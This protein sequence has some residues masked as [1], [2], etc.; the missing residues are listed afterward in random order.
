[1][2]Y[3]RRYVGDFMRDTA[4]LSLAEVGAYDRLLD[5]QYG[6]EAGLPVDLQALCRVCHAG[7][8]QDRKVVK[9][10][11]ETYFPIVE[12]LRWNPRARRELAVGVTA[13]EKMKEGGRAGAAKRWGKDGAPHEVSDGQGSWG[14]DG[15]TH[16]ASI[17]PP[18][19]IHQ[20][21]DKPKIK[22]LP[23]AALA[24]DEQPVLVLKSAVQKHNSGIERE[25]G[26]TV[27]VWFAYADA[28]R[29]RY[30]VEPVRNRTVNAQLAQL[31]SRL[32]MEAAPPVASFYVAH[33]FMLY[34]RAKHPVNLLLRDA[35]GLHTE[36]RR[37][38]TV[39]SAE[40]QQ[41]DRTAGI[42]QVWK[43]LIEE[44][45]AEERVTI[46]ARGGDDDTY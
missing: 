25:A 3:Y 28:Y 15:V 35:E 46:A 36:W 34:V 32:G 14:N 37:G 9:Q 30:G 39:T 42:G 13:I 2:N 6:T 31:V 43:N 27:P 17:H 29:A 20:P 21:P 11:A 24:A 16:R 45:E 22:S 38:R 1:M 4:H 12:G 18:T 33:D 19:T 10:I 5:V 44:V 26:I 8:K 40:A 23:L 41:T 7:S